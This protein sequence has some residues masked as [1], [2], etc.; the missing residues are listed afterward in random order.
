MGV[1]EFIVV[2]VLISTAGKV[3]SRRLDREKPRGASDQVEPGEVERIRETLDDL[4]GRVVR[5]EEERDF[6]KELLE[7]PE[8]R[9][10]LQ[11]PRMD[12]G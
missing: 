10:E 9:R 11:R 6:Y 1:F 2:L 8:K 3:V 7:S 4:N 5:L 12:D